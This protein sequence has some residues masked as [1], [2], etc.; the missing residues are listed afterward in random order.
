MSLGFGSREKMRTA[1]S[2]LHSYSLIII[3]LIGFG[4]T[5]SDNSELFQPGRHNREVIDSP[6]SP[7]DVIRRL[8]NSHFYTTMT[9]N[10]TRARE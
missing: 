10:D 7:G 9:F 5:G 3:I 2:G 6:S 8:S 1:C 4:F